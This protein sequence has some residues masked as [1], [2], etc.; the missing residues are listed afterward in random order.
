MN[1]NTHLISAS[2]HSTANNLLCSAI[3]LLTI[4]FCGLQTSAQTSLNTSG[5]NSSRA[6]GSV[7]YSVEQ[8]VNNNV[9][10]SSGSVA[11]GVQIPFDISVV[12]GVE[13]T[14]IILNLMVYPNP[15]VDHVFLKM[16]LTN[17]TTDTHYSLMDNNNKILINS[18]LAK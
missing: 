10:K 8:V 16:E 1:R 2:K 3:L 11:E 18:K 9:T 14:Q 13:Q 12:L 7:S 15:T 5:G 6:S 4:G 17:Q